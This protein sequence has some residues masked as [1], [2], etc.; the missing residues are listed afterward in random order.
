[1]HTYVHGS[2]DYTDILQPPCLVAG[3]QDRKSSQGYVPQW[4]EGSLLCWRF[5]HFIGMELLSTSFQ[6]FSLVFSCAECMCVELDSGTCVSVQLQYIWS[7]FFFLFV[8]PSVYV[9]ICN[10]GLL[11]LCVCVCCVC[12]CVCYGVFLPSLSFS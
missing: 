9:Y 11:V 5:L 3:W 1:M 4:S 12:V 2:C 7:Q 8:Y 6:P 10:G